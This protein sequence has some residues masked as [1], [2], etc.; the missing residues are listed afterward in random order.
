M[1]QQPDP[2]IEE[3]FHG[4]GKTMKIG[5]VADIFDTTPQTIRRL[6]AA[7]ALNAY[8]PGRDYLFLTEDVRDLFYSSRV[9]PE[10]LAEAHER[11]QSEDR[12][13]NKEG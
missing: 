12:K 1:S 7:G 9:D 8:R 4:Q 10:T 6:I 2:R 3:L 13:F 5:A 11:N